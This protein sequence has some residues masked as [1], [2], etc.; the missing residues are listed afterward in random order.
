MTINELGNMAKAYA[1]AYKNDELIG[2]ACVWHF[3]DAPAVQMSNTQFMRNFGNEPYGIK[4]FGT[5]DEPHV[6]KVWNVEGVY[7]YALVRDEEM[8][9]REA[10]YVGVF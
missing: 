1:D 5:K 9:D 3:K 2:I 4:N 6:L 10:A 8:T 7:F